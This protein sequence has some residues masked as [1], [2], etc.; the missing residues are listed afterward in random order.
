MKF[1]L[2]SS[3]LIYHGEVFSVR[4]DILRTPADQRINLDIVEHDDAVTILPLDE[5]GRVWFVR[6][7]RH[8]AERDLLELPAGKLEPM[9]PPEEC[10]RREIREE[11]GM[12]AE[13]LEKLGSFYLAPG[14]STEFMHV[15]LATGLYPDPLPGD[16]DEFLSVTAFPVEKVFELAASG[17][18]IDA[19][20]LAALLFFRDRLEE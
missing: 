9:E 13:Q 5:Q 10:A 8:A 11:I 4:R 2:I 14:Y 20:S 12:A 15:Y 18:L 6:Q 16:E 19:K 3:E 17:Q 7:Y 1:K